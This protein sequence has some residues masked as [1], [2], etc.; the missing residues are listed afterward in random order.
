MTNGSSR[1]R[2]SRAGYIGDTC[3]YGKINVGS[4]E[5]DCSFNDYIE[6]VLQLGIFSSVGIV[7][8]YGSQTN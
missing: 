7:Q 1:I 6:S 4:G 2:S 3:N 5:I 8:L